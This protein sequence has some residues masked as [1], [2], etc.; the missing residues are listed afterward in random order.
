MKPSARIQATIDILQQVATAPRPS[1]ALISAYFRA[2]RFIGSKD[3]AAIADMVYG[4][5][6]HQA[7]LT[8][9]QDYL[10]GQGSKA[11]DDRVR[12]RAIIYLVLIAGEDSDTIKKLFNGDDY[13]PQD[14][15]GDE[16]KLLKNLQGRTL[17]HPH[18]DEAVAHEC[19][20]W[21]YAE[22]KEIFGQNFGAEMEALL[23]EAPVDIRINPIKTT[24]EDV[25]KKLDCAAITAAPTPFSPLGLRIVGRP[26]LSQTNLYKDGFIEVQDEA[27][28]LV[29]LLTASQSGMAVVDFCAGAGGKTLA[30]AALM[31]NK[32]RVVACDVMAGR[33]EKAR[34]RFRRAGLH[35]ID[36]R[37]LTNENDKW[38]GRSAEK[39]DRVLVDAP[40]SGS[41]TWRRH[42]DARWKQLGPDLPKLKL[43][44]ANILNSAARLVKKG[45]RL[46]Y[47][48]CSLLPSEN[49][50]QVEAFL[51]KNKDFKI[52]PVNDIA[53]DVGIPGCGGLTTPM[54]ILTPY[55]HK[56]DGFFCA[57][58]VRDD[59]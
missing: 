22:L 27:S 14:L 4:M 20:P 31:Q 25:L 43:M 41:G 35:N 45:G 44:Q 19:P 40:C 12:A 48:T 52:L 34:V 50:R 39:Y 3:R 16:I 9:W 46:I 8:W 21:A 10:Q 1:D 5:M 42:P 38:V 30:L 56:T 53:R 36:I 24:R 13:G 7:R 51:Q 54:L 57:V 11:K 29:A 28:Q 58:M 18:M 49:D 23:Q 15:T 2:H 33:L 6:R 59:C 47:A 55:Q 37:T 26:P 17:M 32:G